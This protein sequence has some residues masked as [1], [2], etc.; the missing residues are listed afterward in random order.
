MITYELASPDVN[1]LVVSCM[2]Q[3]HQPLMDLGVKI[4]VLMIRSVDKDGFV[5]G[6]PPLKS[7]GGFPA[8]ARIQVVPLRDRISKQ[9]DAEIT[10]DAEMWKGLNA[11]QHKALIDH[12]LTHLVIVTAK[13]TGVPILDDLNRPKLRLQPDNYF[14]W[15]FLECAARHGKASLEFLSVQHLAQEHGATLGIQTTAHVN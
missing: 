1:D 8:A 7:G 9:T 5:T 11:D 14:A 10:I 15:G 4:G 13:K 3:Y 2:R 6:K 12:E